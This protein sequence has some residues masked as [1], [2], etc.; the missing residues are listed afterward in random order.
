MSL[1]RTAIARPVTTIMF[2]LGL[3]FIGLFALFLL[4]VDLMPSAGAPSLTVF[5]GIRG[6]LPPE[7]I[8]S[9]VTKVVE[10]AVAT[11]QHLRNMMS[12]SRKDRAVTTLTFEPGTDVGFAAL[13]VQERMAK[14]KNKL[15]K[16]IEK[17][18]VAHYAE[19]D[20]PVIIISL[21]SDQKTPEQL[22][23]LVDNNLKPKLTRVTGVANV[24]VGGGRERK[25]L[26]ELDQ[27]RVEA[28]G[29]N[30]REIT[31]KIGV[32]NLNLQAGK[33]ETDRNTLQVRAIGQYATIE[34]MKKLSIAV[35]KEGSRITLGDI[36]TVRDFYMD[37]QS[38]ARLNGKPTV[39]VYVQKDSSSNTIRVA[40]KV[41][42]LVDEFQKTLDPDVNMMII[43]DQSIFIQDAIDKVMENLTGG[44]LLTWIIIFLFVKEWKHTTV[45]F[46]TAPITLL[47]TLAFMYLCHIALNVMTLSALAL[48]TGMVVDNAAVALQN[49]LRVKRLM[50]AKDP[51]ADM[52]VA[53]IQGTEEL[54][55]S[56]AAATITIVV[57][58]LPIVFIN[59]QVKI[60]YSGL[61]FTITFSMII[62]LFVALTIVPIMAAR[63][64]LP[65]YTG[66]FPPE[67]SAWMKGWAVY[68]WYSVPW[69]GF[70]RRWSPRLFV[71]GGAEALPAAAAPPVDEGSQGEVRPPG[72]IRRAFRWTVS[73]PHAVWNF[74]KRATA[75][76]RAHPRR[77]FVHWCAQSVR[78]QFYISMSLAAATALT[79]YV[80]V[81]LLPKDFLGSTEQ[82]EFVIFVELPAGAKLEVSDQ[83]VGDVEKVLSETPEI[84]KVVKTAASRVEGW[85]SKVYVTLNARTERSRSVQEIIA[86]LRPKV[87]DIGSQYDA[88]IYFSEPEASKEFL[89]DV[90]GRDYDKLRDLASGVAQK[91]QSVKGLADIKLRYKPGRPEV[92]I[93]IDKEKAAMFGFTV[94]DIAETL[95]NQIRGMRATYFYTENEQIESVIRLEEKYRKTLEDVHM[96]TIPSPDNV[97]VPIEQLATFEYALTPSEIWRKDKQR[98]IQVSA[99]REHLPLSEAAQKAI[100]ALK[101][102]D[103]PEGY[104]FQ[105]GG[106][107]VDMTQNEKEFRFAFF[108]M[109]GLVFIVLASM[110]ESTLQAALVMATIPMAFIGSIPLLYFTHTPATMGVYIGMIMMGGTVARDA[111]ILVEKINAGRMEEG[112]TLH[113]AV[114]EAS[115]VR[116]APIL[117]TS[118]TIIM[119]LVPMVASKSE[120]A[121]LWSPLAL[122][123]IGGMTVSTFLTLFII[124]S[125]YF[126]VEKMRDRWT[127]RIQEGF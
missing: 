59:K 10:E 67:V 97:M 17:P 93:V 126:Y 56:L 30:I 73:R 61:A 127:A 108:I 86:A 62:S 64:P 16:D 55:M 120:S 15:P 113:R 102:A 6:G 43:S 106:D 19:N 88:F 26:I 22:R 47:I 94:K 79:V 3:C 80:Y 54:G 45:I 21:T 72:R 20:Y 52:T 70:M 116:L 28:Y 12:V 105:V 92:Q 83:I 125:L 76:L 40:K 49:I 57:V 112:R 101:G 27:N 41:K 104:Y 74:G 5:V 96:L 87:A 18:I 114:L 9:L 53:A 82:N 98:M 33:T 119:D 39:S 111:I 36:A 68:Y 69:P 103:V 117:S 50:L 1:T 35:T 121:Q 31:G 24:E 115:L 51:N 14:I 81:A 71:Y 122:T 38:K 34:D 7:D 37:E 95:H 23:D 109:A 48:A 60:L 91:L 66:Y 84:A 44:A 89:I 75:G 63:L 118:L 85:S 29:L 4:P 65:S 8:E 90:F 77:T 107:Y 25:I 110:F 100:A 78:K 124:P 2:Y 99:N 42:A 58:F 32:N 11:T 46:L 13:E 123:V